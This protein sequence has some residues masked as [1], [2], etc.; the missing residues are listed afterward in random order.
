M[1]PADVAIIMRTQDRPI[2]LDRAIG[3]ILRQKFRNWQLVVVSD[4]GNLPAIQQVMEAHSGPLAGRARLLHRE[5]SVGMEAATNFGIANSTGRYIAVHDDDDTWHA[6]FLSK[7]VAYLDA[8]DAGICGVVAG[9]A[10]V[11]ER[12]EGNRL[13]EATRRTL[14]LPTAP[15]TPQLLRK[16]NPFPPISFLF[17][18]SAF[19]DVGPY[20][21]DLSALGD[22]EFNIRLAQRFRIGVIPETLAFWHIR[23]GVRGARPGYANSSYWAHLRSLMKL[24]REW[25]QPRPLWRYVLLWRY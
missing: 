22:W 10:L 8:S 14:P 6:E 2:T 23:R 20:R 9:T 12:F 25:G 11:L 4:Q 16:R 5:R 15:M 18:R 21:E 13:V 7:A 1:M 19:E 24:K 17:R 3:E